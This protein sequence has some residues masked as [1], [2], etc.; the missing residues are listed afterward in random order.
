M[1]ILF[2]LSAVLALQTGASA[3]DLYV[4]RDGNVEKVAKKSCDCTDSGKCDCA[5][6]KC[7]CD[8]CACKSTDSCKSVVAKA[9]DTLEPAGHWEN[10]QTCE[11]G[12]CTIRKV[13]VPNATSAAVPCESCASSSATYSAPVREFR[14]LRRLLGAPFRLFGGGC[15]R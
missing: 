3:A 9:A 12:R 5:P 11:N 15:C 10:V 2:I 6:G 8:G 13:W 7:D 14:P 4:L 1:R